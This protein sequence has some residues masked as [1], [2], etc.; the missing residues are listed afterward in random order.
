MSTPVG[1]LV[2]GVRGC[3]PDQPIEAAPRMAAALDRAEALLQ[4]WRKVV[5]RD[6]A[7]CNDWGDVLRRGF[8]VLAKRFYGLS[9]VEGAIIA[10]SRDTGIVL[11]P[12]RMEATDVLRVAL[13]ALAVVHASIDTVA[14]HQAPE[15]MPHAG[16]YTLAVTPMDPG[17][18]VRFA[19]GPG[20]KYALGGPPVALPLVEDGVLDMVEG[21]REALDSAG[22]MLGFEP[23]DPRTLILGLP[24]APGPA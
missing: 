5:H 3:N 7:G 1:I 24:P 14:R 6:V 13:L 21:L 8:T 15:G 10:D 22:G 9:L 11:A 17:P 20:G 2:S 19:L 4:A 16:P 12:T 23:A 18:G